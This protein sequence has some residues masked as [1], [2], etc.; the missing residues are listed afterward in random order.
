MRFAT[1]SLLLVASVAPGL[2]AEVTKTANFDAPPAKVWATIG[3]FCGIGNW[4]PAV[5][6]CTL[7]SSSSK[8]QRTL[9]LKGG[10]TIVEEQ[11]ARDDSGMSYTYTILQSPLPVADY[12]STISVA[13]NGSGSK[14]TWTGS[15]QAKGA[16]DAKAEDVIGGI[17]DAGFKG[18]GDK[19]K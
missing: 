1:A 2:A 17:Y 15:F 6:K 5:E 14:V 12:R 13:P 9:A 4:H 19:L 7:D 10:G 11:Q 3:D 16:S 18:I 8:P